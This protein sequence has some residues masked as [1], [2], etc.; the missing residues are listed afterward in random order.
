MTWRFF[1]CEIPS[2]SILKGHKEKEEGSILP[3]SRVDSKDVQE[4]RE[5][6]GT[7]SGE[8]ERFQYLCMRL[9]LDEKLEDDME[10]ACVYPY[11]FL[12]SRKTLRRFD[13]C[14]ESDNLKLMQGAFPESEIMCLIPWK[15][16][17]GFVRVNSNNAIE[18]LTRTSGK[19]CDAVEMKPVEMAREVPA[20][21][22]TTRLETAW[23]RNVVY[24]LSG[25]EDLVQVCTDDMSELT[26][27]LIRRW[28]P[29]ET[30]VVS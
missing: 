20:R 13:L 27:F 7:Q 21:T 3:G 5:V 4:L 8:L 17:L 22:E 2:S 11:L 6:A 24:A 10:M 15:Q 19:R 9:D 25:D 14:G 29:M 26:A 18:V 1:S 16:T 23:V 28:N 30:C 12:Y